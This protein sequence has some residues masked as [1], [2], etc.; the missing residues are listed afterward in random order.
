MAEA[1]ALDD[2]RVPA[3]MQPKSRAEAEYL[4][5][6]VSC[7]R[8]RG[9]D[10]R[11]FRL[12]RRTVSQTKQ[13]DRGAACRNVGHSEAAPYSQT[14]VLPLCGVRWA[15]VAYLIHVSLLASPSLDGLVSSLVIA[16]ARGAPA[17][18]VQMVWERHLQRRWEAE[19]LE[20]VAW[21]IFH[22]QRERTYN[23]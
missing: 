18:G 17:A 21:E 4:L 19:A 22:Y 7:S 2:V 14:L 1:D 6:H 12:G 8:A 20:N 11:K 16:A 15:A 3:D 5:K 23:E 13:T 10:G 9:S